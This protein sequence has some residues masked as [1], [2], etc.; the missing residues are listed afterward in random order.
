MLFRRSNNSKFHNYSRSLFYFIIHRQDIVIISEFSIS[1][2][3][4]RRPHSFWFSQT[5]TKKKSRDDK[6][7]ES[8]KRR[9]LSGVSRM[10]VIVSDAS[11][12]IRPRVSPDYYEIAMEPNRHRQCGVE[13]RRRRHQSHLAHSAPIHSFFQRSYHPSPALRRR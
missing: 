11:R 6:P 5:S 1:S 12:I 9:G 8:I 7:A 4:K 2:R 13:M 3:N 10:T